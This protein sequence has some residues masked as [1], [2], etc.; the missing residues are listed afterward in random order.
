MDNLEKEYVDFKKLFTSGVLKRYEQPKELK[1]LGDLLKYR[2]M[3]VTLDGLD[4]DIMAKG[5]ADTLSE[6]VID[7]MDI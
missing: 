1:E 7:L 2:R 6:L 5:L 3:K 4:V